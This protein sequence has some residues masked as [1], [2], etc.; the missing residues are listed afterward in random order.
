[1]SLVLVNS[2]DISNAEYEIFTNLECSTSCNT[3]KTLTAVRI[4]YIIYFFFSSVNGL[5]KTFCINNNRNVSS[6]E[7]GMKN[8]FT[9]IST[10]CIEV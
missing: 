10:D 5:L 7:S 1:M 6:C 4:G 2:I 9:V 8:T 3:S